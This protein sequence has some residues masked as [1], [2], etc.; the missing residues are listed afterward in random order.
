[1]P[2]LDELG[3]PICKGVLDRVFWTKKKKDYSSD[4][5][6][7]LSEII[8]DIKDGDEEL[9]ERFI[10]EYKPFIL[11]CISRHMNAY[12]D[13]Q[14]NEE[15][16]IGLIAFNEAIDKYD[17]AKGQNFLSFAELVIKSRLINFKKKE[18]KGSKIIPFSFFE[19]NKQSDLQD[20]ISQKSVVLHFDRFETQEELKI[21]N[22]KLE[23]FGIT[24]EDLLARSPKH[25]DSKRLM[26]DIAKIIT[27]ND[28]MYKKLYEKKTIPMSELSAYISVNPKTV[29]RNRKYIIAVCLA[30]GSELEI[31]KG[32]IKNF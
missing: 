7:N 20:S 26:V 15:F 16:S 6:G 31:I 22:S 9:R 24:L 13:T 5:S 18:M 23:S 8:Q 27:S 3:F 19:E 10:D 32:F 29:E 11:G 25:K 28:N 21:Y 12:I 2:F 4:K 17:R 14:N 30:L 1:M